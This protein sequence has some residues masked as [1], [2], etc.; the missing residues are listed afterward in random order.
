MAEGIAFPIPFPAASSCGRRSVPDLI[1][2]II[3]IPHLC[4]HYYYYC[5]HGLRVDGSPSFW[6]RIIIITYYTSIRCCFYEVWK[7]MM[8]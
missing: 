7:L 5:T 4:M 3:I 8:L 1:I 6:F 2:T